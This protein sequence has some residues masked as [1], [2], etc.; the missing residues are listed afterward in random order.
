MQFANIAQQLRRLAS[1]DVMFRDNRSQGEVN[2]RNKIRI[3]QGRV[4]RQRGCRSGGRLRCEHAAFHA[5]K[6]LAHHGARAG[7]TAREG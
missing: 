3:W 5:F 6:R 4:C 2:I 7:R 1:D